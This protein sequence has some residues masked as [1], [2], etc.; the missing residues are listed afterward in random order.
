MGN[1]D[2]QE[3]IRKIFLGFVQVFVDSMNVIKPEKNDPPDPKI[4]YEER[5][6]AWQKA[7]EFSKQLAIDMADFADNIVW[8]GTDPRNL[9][10][11]EVHVSQK[12]INDLNEVLNSGKFNEYMKIVKP[13]LPNDPRADEKIKAWEKSFNVTK[14]L[15]EFTKGVK[16][17]I[18]ASSVGYITL[19][20][21]YVH[22]IGLINKLESD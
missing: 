10:D 6:H 1:W 9:P 15:Q 7:F 14:K 21:Y 8:G 3:A 11:L 5:I 17:A 22:I 19:V 20:G 4:T 18:D 13:N 2:K 16:T 12:F